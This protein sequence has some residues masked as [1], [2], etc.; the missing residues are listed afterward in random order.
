[1]KQDKLIFLL[2]TPRSGSTLLQSLLSKSNSVKTT[3]E[4][5]F[6]LPH[7][8]LNRPDIV[9]SSFDWE[10]TGTAVNEFIKDK[11]G[12]RIYV[13]EQRDFFLRIYSRLQSCD[14][15]FVLDKTPRYFEI[16]EEIKAIF[17]DANYLYL[18]RN[19]LSILISII[20]YSKITNY[21]QLLWWGRDLLV[22]P[23]KLKNIEEKNFICKYEDLVRNPNFV[24]SELMDQLG[25]MKEN[26]DFNIVDTKSIKGT[27]GDSNIHGEKEIS[28]SSIEKWKTLFGSAK[29]KGFAG[30]YIKYLLDNDLLDEEYKHLSRYA[31]SDKNFKLFYQ[32]VISKMNENYTPRE[33]LYPYLNYKFKSKFFNW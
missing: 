17:P 2:S 15:D 21:S 28:T 11:I 20:E 25:L 8:V 30:G 29:W 26:L 32:M 23:Q 33:T 1:M 18:R 14:T 24:V 19:P 27:F 7:L 16:T 31:T 22:A 12:T 9:K 5:W 13:E 4:P 6:L 3:S 10:A